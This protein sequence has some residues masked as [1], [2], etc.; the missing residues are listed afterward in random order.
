M[1]E[2]EAA[3]NGKVG[4]ASALEVG[5]L[6]QWLLAPPFLRPALLSPDLPT[7]SPYH[8]LRPLRSVTYVSASRGPCRSSGCSDSSRV[9]K[10]IS[11]AAL[12]KYTALLVA[13]LLVAAVTMPMPMA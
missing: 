9:M 4:W 2:W 11:A 13:E 6:Q 5:R 10:T 8:A 3:I 12:E 1:I 7:R